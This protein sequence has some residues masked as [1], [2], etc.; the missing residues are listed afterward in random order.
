MNT[1]ETFK[2][3]DESVGTLLKEIITKNYVSNEKINNGETRIII[4]LYIIYI[5]I[6][7]NLNL[8]IDRLVDKFKILNKDSMFKLLVNHIYDEE[9]KEAVIKINK[10]RQISNLKLPAQIKDSDIRY[11]YGE[12]LLVI[13]PSQ[14]IDFIKYHSD[15]ILIYVYYV[16][17]FFRNWK[18]ILV[19]IFLLVIIF[20]IVRKLQTCKDMTNI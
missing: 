10:I 8:L 17:N 18:L 19:F 2:L 15:P 9:T 7:N 6:K 4:D 1:N 20:L 11:L 13:F 14:I 12:L 5:E 3:I 16:K